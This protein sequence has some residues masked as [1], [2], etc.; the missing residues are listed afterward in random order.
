MNGVGRAGVVET[1][2]ASL[3]YDEA[4]TGPPVVLVHS[5]ITDRRMWDP[6][7]AVLA[8]RYRTIRYDMQGFGESTATSEGTNRDE[9][10]GLVDAL[11][12]KGA[13]VVACSFGASVALDATLEHP[14]RARSLTLIGPTVG[15]HEYEGSDDDPVWTRVEALYDA[16]VAA[17]EAGDYAAA[18][19]HEVALWVVGPG[20][21]P[22]AVDAGLLAWVAE[23]NGAALRNEAAGRRRPDVSRLDP[24]AV[25]RL[26]TLAVPLHVVVGADDLPVVGDAARTLVD[27]VPGARLSVVTGAAHLPSVERPDVVT[28]L[29]VGFWGSLAEG[30]T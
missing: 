13:H 26:E 25:D 16:S 6:L 27:R 15:G 20:R 10:I 3:A 7:V 17:Y 30:E 1:E 22:E 11:G 12:V 14:E 21:S 29:L 9:L 2:T 19:E 18:A 23:M 8:D 5:G 24:P 4:G 28:D